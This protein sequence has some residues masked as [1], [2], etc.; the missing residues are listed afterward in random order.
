MSH[1][2]FLQVARPGAGTGRPY[3]S[4]P[5]RTFSFTKA[6]EMIIEAKLLT[7]KTIPCVLGTSCPPAQRRR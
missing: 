5:P 2:L 4:D 3:C 1:G 6:S 7:M